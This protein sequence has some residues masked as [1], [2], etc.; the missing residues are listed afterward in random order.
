M[1]DVVIGIGRNVLAPNVPDALVA[2]ARRLGVT[3]REIDLASVAIDVGS[4]SVADRDGAVEVTHL[5]PT[6]FYWADAALAAF[7]LLES[8]GAIPINPVRAARIA[9][10]KAR[11]AVVLR[12]VG[13]PQLVTLVTELSEEEVFG[14]IG[15]VG[16]PCVLKRTHGAQ[17]RW[18]RRVADPDGVRAVLGEFRAEGPSAVIVQELATDFVGRSIRV[19]V[20]N[21]SVLGSALR[22]GAPGSFVSNISAG[23]SQEAVDLSPEEESMA[24]RAA[25][26]V[27]LGFAGVDICRNGGRSFVLEVNSCPDFTSMIP[28]L[29]ERVTDEVLRCVMSRG[30]ER[31]APMI[32]DDGRGSESG[33]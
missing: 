28:L 19:L 3:V 10:D 24:V 5:A 21:G 7:E 6:L 25:S 30:R 20:S 23:G 22:I 11:T 26:A 16:Y 13:V 27:G 8:N 31:K 15:R 14:A 29:G 32:G 33:R 12:T 4:R 18:V 17:G 2:A 9:D 1:T